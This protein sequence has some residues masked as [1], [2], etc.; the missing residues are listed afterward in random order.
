MTHERILYSLTSCK[1]KWKSAKDYIREE[2]LYHL[3]VSQS[4]IQDTDRRLSLGF[5]DNRRWIYYDVDDTYTSG[6]VT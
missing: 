5:H 1:E 6:T 2:S 3:G 4:K